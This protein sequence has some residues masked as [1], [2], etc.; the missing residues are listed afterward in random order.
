MEFW[1]HVRDR[2]EAVLQGAESTTV[3]LTASLRAFWPSQLQRSHR[4]C[5][6]ASYVLTKDKRFHR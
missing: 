5:G 4:C 1:Q 6:K 2:D 3:R